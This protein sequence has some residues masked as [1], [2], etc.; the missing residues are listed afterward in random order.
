MMHATTWFERLATADGE[1][2]ERLLAALELLGPDA[3]SVLTPL[4][5]E[6]G[7]LDDAFLAEPF[8]RARGALARAAR[9]LVR[10]SRPATAA[11]DPRAG[12][13]SDVARRG[14]HVAAWRVHR[15]PPARSRGGLVIAE[16]MVTVDGRPCGAGRR[17]RPGDPGDL[18][19]RPRDRPRRLG[20]RRGDPGRSATDVRRHARR[21]M[22]SA[23][24]SRLGWR[25]SAGRSTSGSSSPSRGRPNGSPRPAARRS[26]EAG[27]HRPP[28]QRPP[29]RRSSSST[30][31]SR[32]RSAARPGLASTMSS[33]RRSAARSA[34][35]PDCRQP[36]EQF[37]DV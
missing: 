25:G 26:A 32:A 4:P 7:L 24:P 34:T 11:P 28:G 5:N 3:G 37:K 13:G 19:R 35:A 2:R 31:P 33:A 1:P 14:V 30:R 27:S 6:R 12:P 29:V 21:S 20:Q 18:D 10:A 16:P 17:P 22:R 9:A 36:F 23:M 15:R 8:A